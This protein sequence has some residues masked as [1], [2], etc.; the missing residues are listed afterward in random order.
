[1]AEF[2]VLNNTRKTIIISDLEE[3]PSITGESIIDLLEYTTSNK[4]NASSDLE[5]LLAEGTLTRLS[6]Q[7]IEEMNQ[8]GELEEV[9]TI[10]E[11]ENE[12]EEE[13]EEYKV[14]NMEQL[15]TELVEHINDVNTDIKTIKANMKGIQQLLQKMAQQ[16]K[17]LPKKMI[18][19]GGK[20]NKLKE[21]T[22]SIGRIFLSGKNINKELFQTLSVFLNSL[23][24]GITLQFEELNEEEE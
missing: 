2:Y 3:L 9:E 20:K 5:A 4:I 21:S 6:Q 23:K 10:P 11:E 17:E 19:Y 15:P 1:M 22:N 12:D 18:K 14:I 7:Q 24:L 8:N 13:D 16:K